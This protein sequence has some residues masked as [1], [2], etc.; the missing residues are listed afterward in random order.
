[1]AV[2]DEIK[3][4]KKWQEHKIRFNQKTLKFFRRSMYETRFPKLLQIMKRDGSL[5]DVGCGG[6][7]QET[8]DIISATG[9]YNY[10]LGVDAC[11]QSIKERLEWKENQTNKER[12]EFICAEIQKIKFDRTFDVVFLS[13]VIEHLSFEDADKTIDYLL[14]LTNYQMI[15]ETPNEFEDGEVYVRESQNG[16]QR[17]LSLID[18]KYLKTKGF[19]AIHTYFQPSGY[20]NTIYMIKK[21]IK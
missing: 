20:S 21:E 16:F 6:I 19:K 17:H 3:N 12:F 7:K 4:I 13:H 5:L 2:K 8:F 15:I 14:S 18:G 10:V 9:N 1:M 11:E